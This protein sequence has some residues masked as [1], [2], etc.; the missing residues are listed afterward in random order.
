TM[1]F[2]VVGSS[3]SVPVIPSSDLLKV[4]EVRRFN[5][6]A[7]NG[8]MLNDIDNHINTLTAQKVKGVDFLALKYEMIE[9]HL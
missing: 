7:L 6:E 4:K 3:T 1:S 8:G 2:N 9:V 5:I